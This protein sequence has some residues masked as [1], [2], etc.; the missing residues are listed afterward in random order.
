MKCAKHYVSKGK[1]GAPPI[2]RIMQNKLYQNKVVLVVV[3][4]R[5]CNVIASR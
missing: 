2:K 5:D 1:N 4:D 3:Q